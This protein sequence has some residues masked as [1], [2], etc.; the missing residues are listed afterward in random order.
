MT[1]LTHK[2]VLLIGI[3][4]A[5]MMGCGYKLRGSTNNTNLPSSHYDKIQLSVT[6]TKADVLIR[7]QL[8][9]MGYHVTTKTGTQA[10]T[11]NATPAIDINNLSIQRYE[12]L[13]I[14]TEIRLI[15]IADVSYQIGLKNHHYTLQAT[16]SYQ[17]NKAGISASDTEYEQIKHWL[18]QDIAR[19][20]GEQHRILLQKNK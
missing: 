9:L 15:L 14:L 16:R 7:E 12:L 17:Y 2:A 19:Q 6:D 13:G 20:I 4:A 10:D 5:M 8:Q 3:I 11:P 18:Y 1:H